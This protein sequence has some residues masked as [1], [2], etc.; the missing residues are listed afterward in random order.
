MALRCGI[1]AEVKTRG[2]EGSFADALVRFAGFS[3]LMGMAMLIL[4]GVLLLPAYARL[5]RFRHQRNCE[6]LRLKE[7]RATV[8]AKDRLIEK[9]PTDEVLTKRLAWSKLGMVPYNEVRAISPSSHPS[10]LV[11][12]A[13]SKIRYDDPPLPNSRLDILAAK[14]QRPGHRRGLLVLA[15]SMTIAAMLIFA[16]RQGQNT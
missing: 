12:G 2:R 3:A 14:L 7:A 6:R 10:A 5:Q 16:P 9:A 4:A 15:A 13:L 1:K 8:R 11:P